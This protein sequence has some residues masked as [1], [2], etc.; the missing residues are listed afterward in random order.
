MAILLLVGLLVADL[1]FNSLT[2][3][4]AML[5]TLSTPVHW[6]AAVPGQLND[7]FDRHF[8]SRSVLIR[9][10]ERLR[11]E[12]LL[13]QGR[14]LQMAS[15][16]AEN[17]RLRAL[18]GSTAMV[19]NDVQVA[20]LIGVSP[21]PMRHVLVINRGASDGVY[22]GQPLIDAD[23]LVG[24]VL[25]V[26]EYTSR[27]LL[28]TD[29]THS[30]PVQVNRNGVR[31]IAEGNGSLDML[32]VHHIPVTTDIQVGDLL[33]TSGLGGRFPVGYPVGEVVRVDLDPGQP[34]ARILARPSAALD[35]SR[36]VLLVFVGGA[37]PL[38]EASADGA[39]ESPVDAF[40]RAEEA[41][42][43]P[44]PEPELAPADGEGD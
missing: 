6:V 30:T 37:E 12:N 29:P 10:A 27:V 26:A 19:R 24:Q 34:F 18:L 42:G 20:E 7:W 4:R 2:R 33:V 21:D 43:L 36:H 8:R 38:V 13:L 15:L 40:P 22:A 25:E 39:S 31:A 35:R 17:V 1:H 28:I 41:D 44:A 11:R 23:G 14:A 16:Q 5:D 3:T 9:D 32:E